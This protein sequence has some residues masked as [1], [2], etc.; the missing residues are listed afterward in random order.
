MTQDLLLPEAP[1]ASRGPVVAAD[2]PRPMS[3][4]IL[5]NTHEAFRTSIRLQGEALA[6]G[7]RASFQARWHAMQ[8][9][10]A[11][12]QAMEDTTLFVLLD[13]V[14]GGAIGAAGLLDE[15]DEETRFAARVEAAL[16]SGSSALLYGTWAAWREVHLRH[17]AHEEAVVTP[18]TMLTAPTAQARGRVVHERILVPT[19][20]LSDFD[21]TI[22]CVVRL[23]SPYGSTAQ[24]PHV[25]TR[26]FAWGL[27][28][29]CSHA[30]W[31]RLRPI[32][33]RHCAPGVWEAIAGPFGLEGEGA[34][35]DT[36]AGAA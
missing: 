1:A 34:V 10:L 7:N 13:E 16:A 20:H 9:A 27:Q 35:G 19:E 3:F 23:L 32:V 22:A 24:T 11:V 12:H 17:L 4:A 6:L 33:R 26:V 14:S 29:A 8:R 15:H 5:R 31:R 36:S 25:A 18:L 28:N 2:T 21:A 30:Q